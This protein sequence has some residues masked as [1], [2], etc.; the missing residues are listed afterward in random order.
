[1][2]PQAPRS[3]P[4]RE[5]GSHPLSEIDQSPRLR[6]V[7]ARRLSLRPGADRKGALLEDRESHK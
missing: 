2:D 7:Y 1:L 5:P 6:Q 3:L 4:G